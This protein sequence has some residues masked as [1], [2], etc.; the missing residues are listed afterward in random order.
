MRREPGPLTLFFVTVVGGVVVAYLVRGIDEV[1]MHL[2][3]WL[4]ALAVAVGWLVAQLSA[5][6]EDGARSL[7][8][9]TFQAFGGLVGGA[10]LLKA[11]LRLSLSSLSRRIVRWAARRVPGRHRDRYE[12]E[13]LAEL[14]MVGED[15]PLTAL[16]LSLGIAGVAVRRPLG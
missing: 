13:W 3:A 8:H 4:D 10:L 9:P 14:E 16:W 11:D 1:A 5:L 6:A 2:P 12:E 7:G 15:R